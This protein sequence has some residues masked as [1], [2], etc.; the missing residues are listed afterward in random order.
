MTFHRKTSVPADL[1]LVTLYQR[2]AATAYAR[3]STYV[4]RLLNLNHSL[5][6]SQA[7]VSRDR[8][9]GKMSWEFVAFKNKWNT[10]ALAS[11]TPLLISA[12]AKLLPLYFIQ[13]CVQWLLEACL[14]A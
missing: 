7:S 9:L 8:T 13:E 6:A 5:E 2:W 4:A 14:M 3:Q 11:S 1:W 12:A 10:R